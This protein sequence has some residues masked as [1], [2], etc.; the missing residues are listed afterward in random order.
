[1]AKKT[2]SSNAN[3]S[4]VLPLALLR[5]I[6]DVAILN[7][8]YVSKNGCDYIL[9]QR[10]DWEAL[11]AFRGSLDEQGARLGP[12]NEGPLERQQVSEAET[13]AAARALGFPV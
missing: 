2:V 9:I 4:A 11:M 3:Q 1:M 12:V 10:S 8:G 7:G 6:D 5:V 13:W